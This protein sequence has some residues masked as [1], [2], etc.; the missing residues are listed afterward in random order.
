[1]IKN[2]LDQEELRTALNHAV[3]TYC[4]AAIKHLIDFPDYDFT[5]YNNWV[6]AMEDAV[7]EVEYD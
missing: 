7:E 5:E 2:N 1:M 3:V 6:S 4:V